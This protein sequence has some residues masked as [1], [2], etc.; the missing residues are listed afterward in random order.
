VQ[1]SAN[2]TV[3]GASNNDIINLGDGPATVYLGGTGET[4]NGGAGNDT[5]YVTAATI[6]ATIT[7]GSGTNTLYVT[8]GGTLTMGGNITNVPNVH[9]DNAGGYD[10][11]ANA[12]AGLKVYAGTGNDTITVGDGSQTVIGSIRALIVKATADE[13]G[14]L[15]YGG[16]ASQALDI[17]T[18][19][20]VVLNSGDSNLTVNLTA[21]DTLTLPTNTS[22]A[23]SGS[24]GN[25]TLIA[26]DG[27]LRAGQSI[28]LSGSSNTLV[29]QGAG[30]FNLAAPTVLS[31]L[32]TVDVQGAAAGQS[33][34]I[35]LRN[36]LDLTLNVQDSANITVNGAANNDIV[37]LGAGSAVV[38]VGGAGETVTGGSGN[39]TFYVTAASIGATITG[40]SGTNVLTVTGGGTLAMGGNIAGVAN[41]YLD[42]AASYDFA[43][44]ATTGLTLFAGSGSDRVTVGDASQTVKGT[45]GTLTVLATAAAAGVLVQG[46]T[47]SKTLDITTVGAVA[48]NSGDSNLTVQLASGDTLTLPTNTSIAVSGGGNDTLLATSGVLRVG[49][50]I[51]LSGSSN[52]LVA[53]GAGSFNLAAPTLLSGIQTVD[54]TGA[55][56][57][58]SQTIIL[59]NGQ[60]VTLDIQD[61]ANV[62]VSGAA[63]G[64]VTVQATAAQAAVVRVIGA[65]AKSDMILQIADTGTVVLNGN[66]SNLT[67]DLAAGDTLALPNNT[68]IAVT[69]SGNDTLVATSGTL[70]AG[71]TIATGGSGNTLLLQG[72]GS[73]DLRTPAVLSGIQTLDLQGAAAGQSQI[74]WLRDGLDLT[75]NVQDGAAV[76]VYGAAN[77]DIINLGSGNAIVHLGSAGGTVNGGSGNEAFYVTAATIGATIKGGSGTNWLEVTG[78]GTLAMGGNIV[79]VPNV[80][81]DNAASYDF[82]ANATAGLAVYASSGSDTI[83]IGAASQK[84][85]GSTGALTVQATAAT[86]GAKVVGGSG[87]ATLEITNGGTATLNAADTNLTVKLD[88][89]TNLNLGGPG[90][91][92]AI[93]AAGGDTIAAGGANQTLVSTGGSD[94]LIGSAKF[95]DTFQGSA[96]GL[97]GDVIKGFGGSD[98]IDITDMIAA[99]VHPLSFNASTGGLTVTDG[100]HSVSLTISGSY[101]AASFA[102]PVSD[103]HGG[104]LIRF[105]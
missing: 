12:T 51:A 16:T 76:A 95:G 23:V 91:I 20:T 28:T 56:A 41:V 57:G 103:G 4:V 67:V 63:S 8:G 102:T 99:S 31:G 54:V 87:G 6:G 105:A 59:R 96:A 72:T 65:G 30:S 89:A 36:G 22:I 73:F 40:G 7:G 14:V 5:F 29:A 13:A 84:V 50:S 37:N 48:L 32:Q 80:Y 25:D 83:V 74:V 46:G 81:L 10:F 78:G 52:T 90:F 34:A 98:A 94:T 100:T 97:A 104:T 19:G 49:Q 45:A 27:V 18:A 62:T 88:A 3:Y 69:G 39:D 71:Q 17:T 79:N 43:A 15:V 42:N 11:T 24:T 82:T 85:F 9:L 44:N 70:R 55:A 2:V 58:Q 35:T 1:D 26:T 68:S 60:D 47:G 77:N 61:S 66:D 101:T 33:Q 93:G 64:N 38:Y 21:G 75:L 53:Q 86:A 92:T